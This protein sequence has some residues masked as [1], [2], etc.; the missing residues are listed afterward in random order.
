MTGPDFSADG[1]W[2]YLQLQPHRP[3]ADLAHPSDGT[4]LQQVTSDN[5][6]N[7]LPIRR[8]RTAKVVLISY[9]PE[10]FDH[11]RDLH[12]RLR[13]MDMDGGNLTILFELSADGARSMFRTGR[14]MVMNSPMSVMSRPDGSG[15][16]RHSA[17]NFGSFAGRIRSAG[18]ARPT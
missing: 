12:V 18:R 3:D 7:W 17:I 10:V 1:Q 13:L 4:G 9:D 11:P 2:I 5:Y 6:G 8:R 16:V 15:Q 14:L